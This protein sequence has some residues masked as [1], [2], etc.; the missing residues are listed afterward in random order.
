MKGQIRQRGDTYSVIIPL[1]KNECG[2]SKYKWVT[3]KTKR[4][5][6]AKLAEL[7]H[8]ANTG[9][10]ASPKGTLGEFIR[11][12]LD[13][14]CKP[15]LSPMTHEGYESMFRYRMEPAIGSIKLKDLKPEHIQKYYSDLFKAGLAT[16]TARHHAMMLHCCLECAVKWQLLA[17][18]PADAV[19]PPANRHVEMNT[20]DETGVR[21]VLGAAEKTPYF[22]L[23]N[24]AIYSGMRRS[25]LL[26][27][28][29]SDVGLED[30]EIYVSRSLHRLKNHETVFRSTKTAKSNRTVAL[31][32]TMI[33]ILKQHRNKEMDICAATGFP[34]TSER[35]IFCHIDGKPLLPDSVSQA[36]VRHAKSLGYPH[37][38]FHDLRHTSATLMLKAGI[39]PKIVQEKLGHS[40]IVV[41]LDLYS[42]VSPGMQQQAAEKL[43]A[44][45]NQNNSKIIARAV[46]GDGII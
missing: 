14:Y 2:K 29:W 26:A 40:S 31:G 6:Q 23:F 42:H 7:I 17:R 33:E 39:H 19:K 38:R 27:L 25:E 24:L 9:M 46:L 15:N 16:T 44:I 37:I 12:W 32:P 21:V 8:M 13:E 43:D 45:L 34:F 41:T 20:L 11:R 5:A 1:A 35:L 28:R 3:C 18:N 4:E 22:A 36:W 30:G 10:L